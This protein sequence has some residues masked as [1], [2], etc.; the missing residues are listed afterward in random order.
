MSCLEEADHSS[1]FSAATLGL[2]IT[3]SHS[4]DDGSRA[5]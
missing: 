3:C 2:A 5:K 1:Q 4:S